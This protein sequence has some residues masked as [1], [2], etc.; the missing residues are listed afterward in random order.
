MLYIMPAFHHHPKEA[1]I[2]GR[3]VAHYGDLE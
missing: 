2:V 3:L 1:A